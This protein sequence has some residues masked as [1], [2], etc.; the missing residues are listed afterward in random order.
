MFDPYDH[1][2]DFVD[3]KVTLRELAAMH[4]VPRDQ[5]RVQLRNLAKELGEFKLFINA[6][7]R[8]MPPVWAAEED[9]VE[10]PEIHEIPEE[11]HMDD[12]VQKW[13]K[14]G[15][16]NLKFRKFHKLGREFLDYS[17]RYCMENG[18]S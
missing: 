8:K 17:H 12:M 9:V 4:G 1:Y 7:R 6:I 16:S 13:F 10:E 5:V 2:E 11:S 3:Q 18:I 15:M 14:S